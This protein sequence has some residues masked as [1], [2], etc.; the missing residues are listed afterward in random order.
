VRDK[1]S[2]EKYLVPGTREL[3]EALRERGL[4]LYLASGTDQQYMREEAR[5]LDIERYFDGVYT[6]RSTITKASPRSC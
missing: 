2:P 1:V 4:V 6:G 3:V 5:L